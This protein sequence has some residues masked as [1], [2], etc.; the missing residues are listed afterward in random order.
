MKNLWFCLNV[1]QEEDLLPGCLES[2]RKTH[3]EAKI[4]AV[5]GAYHSLTHEVQKVVALHESKGMVELA[6]QL[7]PYTKAESSDRTLEILREAKVDVLIRCAVGSDGNPLPWEHEYTKRSQYFVGKPGDYYCV[8]D[9]D[10]RIVGKL[11]LEK[12]EAPAYN[13]M[14]KRDENVAPYPILRIFRHQDKM[15]YE[16]AHHALHVGDVLY[17]R[18]MFE[19]LECASLDHLQMTRVRRDPVRGIA[20]G[21]YYRFLTSVEEAPFRAQHAL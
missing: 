1:F 8:I 16:G 12:L 19:T 15:R 7:L 14:I 6:N 5:D 21:A 3:P 17:R 20:K 18:E 11:D 4:V 10:E 9:G 13:L 2:I